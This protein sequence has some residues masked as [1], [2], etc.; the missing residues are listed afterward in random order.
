MYQFQLIIPEDGLDSNCQSVQQHPQTPPTRR[1]QYNVGN[2]SSESTNSPRILSIAK[3]QYDKTQIR[4]QTRIKIQNSNHKNSNATIMTDHRTQNAIAGAGGTAAAVATG[5]AVTA[6]SG[7]IAAV[8]VLVALGLGAVAGGGA[9]GF[10]AKTDNDGLHTITL[11]TES[12]KEAQRWHYIL[13]HAINE[14]EGRAQKGSS[15]RHTHRAKKNTERKK[16]TITEKLFVSPLQEIFGRY[17]VDAS[18]NVVDMLRWMNQSPETGIKWNESIVVDGMRILAEGTELSSSMRT[19]AIPV[20]RRNVLGG[21]RRTQQSIEATAPD[22]FVHA[23]DLG[24]SNCTTADSI[25]VKILSHLGNFADIIHVTVPKMKLQWSGAFASLGLWSGERQFLCV[26]RWET[27]DEGVFILT[28]EPFDKDHEKEWREEWMKREE[29]SLETPRQDNETAPSL[30]IPSEGLDTSLHACFTV[31][32]VKFQYI[33]GFM[34][35]KS[36]SSEDSK[37]RRRRQPQFDCLVR[38]TFLCRP[39][40]FLDFVAVIL[41]FLFGVD[42]VGSYSEAL[43]VKAMKDTKIE[44]EADFG[45]GPAMGRKLTKVGSFAA[46]NDAQ[47]IER[48]LSVMRADILRTEE[49]ISSGKNFDIKVVELLKSQ[50]LKRKKLEDDLISLNDKRERSKKAG[51]TFPSHWKI[52]RRMEGESDSFELLLTLAVL[53]SFFLSFHVACDALSRTKAGLLARQIAHVVP[54]VGGHLDCDVLLL[55]LSALVGAA[56]LAE[57]AM[58]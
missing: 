5:I 17:N 9:V 37:W 18:T 36:R 43:M 11:A 45:E 15:L 20:F 28:F 21:A 27:N 26:R 22:V 48:E 38:S 10:N 41:R 8:P 55:I 42:L 58:T 40:G 44:S 57:S 51:R 33:S 32:P 24:Q 4:Q 16:T 30:G 39:G 12:K 34:Q 49:A 19:D 31:S 23:M 53:F 35:G 25:Q 2:G 7:G 47:E 6:L 14:N 1:D 46:H 3:S 54:S 13:A 29:A 50:I 52:A 56:K